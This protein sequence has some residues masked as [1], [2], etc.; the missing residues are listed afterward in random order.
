MT[1][2]RTL[3]RRTLLAGAAVT[4]AALAAPSIVRAQTAEL[5]IGGPGGQE[6]ATRAHLIP[7]F[8]KKYN[9]K[10]LYDGSQ[11][12]PNLQK[13]QANRANPVFDVVMMDDPILL[14]AEK[15]DLIEKLTTSKVPNMGKLVPDAIIRDGNWVNY[16]WPAISISNYVPE[17][18]SVDSWE[19]LWADGFEERV[20]IPHPTTTQAPVTMI[21][22]AH[23]ET[24]KPLKEAQ[25][26]LDAAF[27][28]LATLKLNLLDVF[29][30]S[31]K[32]ATL[33]EQ[34][35]AWMAAGFFTTYTLP[36]KAAGSP[37]DLARPKEGSF[38]MPKGVAKVKGAASPEL[39]DA[40]IDECLGLEFQK[41]WMTEFF[42]APTNAEARTD[43][44]LI[45]SKDLVAIDWG[46]FS[47]KLQETTDRFDREIVG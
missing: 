30:A 31:A 29:T 47:E 15:E 35:E 36:R 20:L 41:V 5:R 23:F 18:P 37:I 45:P 8:E 24:G 44:A 26:D 25:Y 39:A 11:S 9:C 19:M 6:A 33:L 32:A 3:T 17:V 16:M 13:L 46:F 21:M 34:G 1:G 2:H 12:L 38:A 28:R 22:A 42:G 14:I 40:W 4:G 10:V 27:K 43:P 7:A